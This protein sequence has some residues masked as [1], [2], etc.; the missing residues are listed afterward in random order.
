M[1]LAE[2]GILGFALGASQT[3]A[4]PI[5]EFQFADFSTEAVTQLGLNAGTWYFRT[6]CPAPMLVRLPCGGGLTLGA[7]PLRRV[8]RTMVSIPGAETAL[9]GYAP[10]NLRG[11]AGRVLRSQPVPGFRAQAALLE[12]QRRHRFRRRSAGRLAAATLHGRHR[13]DARRPGGDGP[14][15]ADRR[16][17]VGP[18]RRGLEPLRLAA[19]GHRGRSPNRSKRPAG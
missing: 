18:F 4:V 13:P 17:P 15:V 11:P 7:L 2:S 19:T 5:I 16:G 9:P 14:A 1:P 8:R 3:G 12:P 10:G 6:G